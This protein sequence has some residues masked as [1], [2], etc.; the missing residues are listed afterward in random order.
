M[1]VKIG[2]KIYDSNETPI[3][4][5]FEN[6]EEKEC[7]TNMLS[8]ARK[9]CYFDDIKYSTEYIREFMTTEPNE[10]VEIPLQECTCNYHRDGYEITHNVPCC[11]RMGEK[12]FD[13][14]GNFKKV[15]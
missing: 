4:I 9:I 8:D 3:M 6:M 10:Y 15:L 2:D 14:L 11:D 7:V 13:D 5:I 12:D 1:K